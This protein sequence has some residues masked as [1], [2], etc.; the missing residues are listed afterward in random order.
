VVA[1]A[2]WLRDNR[3]RRPP[4]IRRIKRLE[5]M[6][7]NFLRP[8]LHVISYLLLASAAGAATTA[9]DDIPPYSVERRAWQQPISGLPPRLRID[10][11][12]GDIRVRKSDSGKLEIMAAIQSI[13]ENPVTPEIRTREKN[14]ATRIEVR[15]RRLQKPYYGRV[16]L[17]VYA[18]AETELDLRT[19]DAL[20]SVKGG[21]SAAIVAR[22]QSG[23]ISV[24]SSR[25]M[26]I[27]TRTGAII[28]GFLDGK[29]SRHSY[30]RTDGGDI[31]LTLGTRSNLSV[32]LKHC[33]ELHNRSGYFEAAPST[34]CRSLRFAAGAPNH[35]LRIRSRRGSVLIN[36]I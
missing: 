32:A 31:A 9:D 12:H 27:E 11:A 2:W 7:V 5:T 15:Y 10:N 17:V 36:R 24:S 20:I 23:N 29:R 21:W 18:P 33:G 14:G 6:Y 30:L 1:T 16:D 25:H 35:P 22:S 28:A 4:S 3:P 34:G 13:G 19:E 26:Q 8:L